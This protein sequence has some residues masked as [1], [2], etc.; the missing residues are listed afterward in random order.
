MY[1]L[2]LIV[3]IALIVLAV[4]YKRLAKSNNQLRDQIDAL[5]QCN[6]QSND[7]VLA[8]TT[9]RDIIKRKWTLAFNSIDLPMFAH[10]QA[11]RI[12]SANAAY[13]QLADCTIKQALGKPY[14]HIFPVM[15][16]PLPNCLYRH[17][18]PDNADEQLVVGSRIFRSQ[19]FPLIDNGK[20]VSSLHIMEDITEVTETTRNLR[21]SE[22][23]FSAI[24]NSMEE[25]LILL[26]VD[27]NLQ[28][29]N[30][31]ALNAYVVDPDN[32]FGTKCYQALWQRDEIC[33]NCPTVTVAETKKVVKGLRN[34]SDGRILARTIYPIHDSENEIVNY[35]VI[36]TNITERE[37]HFRTL[38]YYKEI[39]TTSTDLIAYYDIN[40]VCILANEVM[41]KYQGLSQKEIIGMHARDIVGEVNYQY[42]QPYIK[43]VFA[44]NCAVTLEKLVD[45]RGLGL[46]NVELTMTPYVDENGDVSSFVARLRDITELHRKKAKLQLMAKVFE[47]ATEGITIADKCGNIEMVNSA[48]SRITGYDA[49][50]V[51]GQNPRVLKSGRHDEVF[52]QQMWNSII[53]DGVWQ[54]EIWNKNKQG[55]IYP[56]WLTIT[57]LHDENNA[58][59]NYIA[60]FSDLTK[61]NSVVKKLEYQAHHHPLTQL[62]NRLLLHARLDFAIQ[63]AKREQCLVAVIHIDL[64]S[65]KHINSS[66][67][68]DAGDQLLLQ[69]A[70][71]LQH[72]CREVDTV[73]HVGADEFVIVISKTSN[74]KMVIDLA[75]KML[76]S[77]RK[78]VSLDGYQMIV[79]ASAGIALFPNDGDCVEKLLKNSAAALHKAKKIDK[80]SYQLYSPALI[81]AIREK[82]LLEHNLRCAVENEEFVLFYQPQVALPEGKIIACEALVRWLFPETGLIAPDK[83][84]PLSEETGLII[85]I[86]EWVLRTACKQWVTWNEQ[87]IHLQRRA[88]NIS[89][90]QIQHN[91]LV[92]TVQRVLQDTGCPA[93]ALEL[94]I[95][96][97]FMMENHERAI[98]VLDDLNAIGVELSIDDFGTGLSSLAYLK[99]FPVKRLKIDRS[100]VNDIGVSKSDDAIVKTIIAMGHGLSMEIIAEGIETE[101][102]WKFLHDNNCDEAQGYLF[103]KPVPANEFEQLVHESLK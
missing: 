102:Q 79:T 55:T 42:Y 17:M 34:F 47:T 9:E 73:A 58:I 53:D 48:F 60:V 3:L 26:D 49:E 71:R 84:I 2:L 54:G 95:T 64:D 99:R 28:F 100:F 69:T 32:Y 45:F 23:R 92:Q 98:A 35:A 89:G 22:Q 38:S 5:A 7:K 41:A 30:K 40:H 70:Q 11:G 94:E 52:Y 27:F 80:G 20:Y 91:D 51:V 83:F 76:H 29:L 82:V 67:G 103:G 14:W 1:L 37:A 31:S 43:K 6:E 86:G 59:T 72:N 50:D 85:P 61:Y 93:C 4:R 18:K 78:P 77:L 68:N 21:E 97:S 8:V 62:P 39:I 101:Q 44:E 13:L 65:F 66:F 19:A 81:R 74:T 12:V 56:E 10:N 90:R 36:A 16:H 57:A 63:Q 96:E 87:G 25:V 75:E 33:E 88:V 24:S 46:R 15:D